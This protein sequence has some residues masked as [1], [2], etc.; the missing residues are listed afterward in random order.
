VVPRRRSSEIVQIELALET[1]A[2]WT[3][4]RRATLRSLKRKGFSDRQLGHA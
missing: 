2:D 3:C 4:H 1:A